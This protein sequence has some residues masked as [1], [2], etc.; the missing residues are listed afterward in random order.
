MILPG[1]T[2]KFPIANEVRQRNA[3]FPKCSLRNQQLTNLAITF[4]F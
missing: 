4:S 3:H 1:S 2:F